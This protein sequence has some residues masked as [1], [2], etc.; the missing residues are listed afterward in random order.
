MGLQLSKRRRAVQRGSAI[1]EGA[2]TL[3][4]FVS[5]FLGTLD[6]AQILLIHQSIVERVRMAARIAAVSCCDATQV[7][8]VVLYGSTT[9]P[10]QSTTGYWGMTASNVAVNFYDQNTANQRVTIRISG[11]SYHAYTPM[12]RGTFQ[13]IP[14][15]ITIP[16]EL[17]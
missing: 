14:V 3:I 13:N 17:P 12:M 11:L 1:V 7:R 6:V 2:L 9:A 15:Q 5:L 8:N 10:Q 4:A 16:L